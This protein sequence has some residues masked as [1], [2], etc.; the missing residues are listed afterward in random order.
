VDARRGQR[1]IPG[2]YGRARWP[3][4]EIT[5]CRRR[6]LLPLDS[7]TTARRGKIRR[8]RSFPFGFFQFAIDPKVNSPNGQQVELGF[9]PAG[10]EP[11]ADMKLPFPDVW[12]DR[13]HSEFNTLV[14]HALAIPI[15]FKY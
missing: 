15:A 9:G 2:F 1:S 14:N 5:A 8:N 6:N 7:C 4:I 13:S 3:G 10:N 11:L 12:S